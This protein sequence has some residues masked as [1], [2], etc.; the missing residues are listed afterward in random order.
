MPTVIGATFL[1][2]SLYCFSRGSSHLFS[3][4]VFSGIFQAA[5]VVSSASVQP[6]YLVALF[7][8]ARCVA[9][10]ALGKPSLH[11]TNGL[12]PLAALGCLGVIS[13]FLYPHIFNGIPVYD[14][15]FGLDDQL[16]FQTSLHFNGANKYQATLLIVNVLVVWAAAV[17]PGDIEGP[18]KKLKLAFMLLLSIL[19]LQF[20]FLYAGL[21]FPISLLNNDQNYMLSSISD[22]MPRPSGTFI[23]PSMA[24]PI[25]LGGILGFLADY[26]STGKGLWRVGLS[27]VGILLVASASSFLALCL[28]VV[29]VVLRYP[30]LRF[31]YYVKVGRLK[32]M[33]VLSSLVPLVAFSLAIPTIRNTLTDQIVNKGTSQSFIARSAADLYAFTLAYQTHG[34]GVGLG[35]NRPSSLV[36][37]IVSTLGVAGLALFLLL[38][39]RLLQNDLGPYSWLKWT[40]LGLV[41]DMSLGVSEFSFPL[42]WVLFALVARASQS[43]SI[44]F[45]SNSAPHCLP[46][47]NPEPA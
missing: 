39:V 27:F 37:M 46:G 47:N 26:I 9:E 30:I 31:P 11:N 35:S 21:T 15:R 40:T 4:L 41:L 38:L 6:Y 13:A 16:F 2:L 45:N 12:Y 17:V 29:L 32:R 44:S 5:T 36:A 19:I 18:S 34:I 10:L 28:G 8:V 25:L 3:L 24:A 14:P 22:K 42:L 20:G 1:I 7:F 43:S 23:E 33:A